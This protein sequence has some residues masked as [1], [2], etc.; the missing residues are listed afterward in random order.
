MNEDTWE[1]LDTREQRDHELIREYTWMMHWL[2][3]EN[4]SWK[5]EWII[6]NWWPSDKQ[7]EKTPE[8][9]RMGEKNSHNQNNYEGMATS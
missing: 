3:L 6:L 9:L 8:L 4:E 1:S 2:D 5:L 7:T